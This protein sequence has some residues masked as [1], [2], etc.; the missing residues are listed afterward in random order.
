MSLFS[1]IKTAFVR[2]TERLN[3]YFGG[4]AYAYVLKADDAAC[5]AALAAG[6][7]ADPTQRSGMIAWVELMGSSMKDDPDF[8]SFGDAA[9]RQLAADRAADLVQQLGR[10]DWKA[11]DSKGMRER[12]TKIAPEYASALSRQDASVFTRRYPDIQVKVNTRKEPAHDIA[13]PGITPLAH[14]E[15]HIALNSRVN[16]LLLMMILFGVAWIGYYSAKIPVA[17]HRY[18]AMMDASGNLYVVDGA[19]GELYTTHIDSGVMA[20]IH[21][22]LP[23][24]RVTL[25]TITVSVSKGLQLQQIQKKAESDAATKSYLESLGK[26]K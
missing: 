10:R 5:V 18:S 8:E 6:M 20:A 3:D 2:P 17:P 15:K 25:D 19:T 24:A 7:I 22:N 13:K 11:S 21:M 9:A 4:A 23:Q 12:L 26:S 16:T 14:A 1:Q